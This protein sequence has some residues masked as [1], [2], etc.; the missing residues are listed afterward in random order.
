[1]EANNR[2]LCVGSA[3]EGHGGRDQPAPGNRPERERAAAKRGGRGPD[4]IRLDWETA[5]V[6]Q[7]PRGSF[8]PFLIRDLTPR[9]QRAFPT[10]KPSAKDFT[11]VRRVIIAV[12]DLDAAVKRYQG[13]L[14]TSG[15]G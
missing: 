15:A 1:M 5:Q 9:Q 14:R 10:G 6:G 8:F 3:R 4:G 11:G 13:G 12:R 7:E 2:P